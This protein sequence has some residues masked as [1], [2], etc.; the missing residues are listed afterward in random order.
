MTLG[1][2][3]KKVKEVWLDVGKF[4]NLFDEFVVQ[5]DV[6]RSSFCKEV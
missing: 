4:G 3:V 2:S 5:G 6:E 1:N